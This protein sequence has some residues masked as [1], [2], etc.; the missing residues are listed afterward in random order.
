MLFLT[1]A[2]ISVFLKK[3]DCRNIQKPKVPMNEIAGMDAALKRAAKAVHL[4]NQAPLLY[5]G[6]WPYC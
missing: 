4:Q 6:D 3:D 1:G 2:V 5:L